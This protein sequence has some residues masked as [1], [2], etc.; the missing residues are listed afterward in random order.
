MSS[1]SAPPVLPLPR[2]ALDRVGPA[3]SDT[4]LMLSG[5][6]DSTW[7]L[8]QRARAGLPTRTHHVTLSDHEGRAA[9]EDRASAA[10]VEWVRAHAAPPAPGTGTGRAED[11][12]QHTS[13]SVGWGT[14]GWLPRNYWL[15]A[16]WAGAIM[17]APR[18]R[19]LANLVIPRHSD[20]FRGGPDSPGAHASDTAYTT[21]VEAM[22]G[23]PVTLTYP[24]LHLAKAQVIESLPAELLALT[25]WCRRPRP[26]GVACHV[27]GTCRQVEAARPDL[28][29]RRP[30]RAR[31]SR[32]SATSQTRQTWSAATPPR[33]ASGPTTS[34]ARR[35]RGTTTVTSRTH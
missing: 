22:T 15:W 17:A 6:I 35:L 23:R 7:C 3:R 30:V 26:G 12:V 8:W 34:A 11:M 13:S 21:V 20:A 29:D 31:S 2:S 14:T 33:A 25:W 18:N 27:C 28:A 24:M 1:S 10:V 16:Y 32:A 19:R 5:G 9:V 4:L